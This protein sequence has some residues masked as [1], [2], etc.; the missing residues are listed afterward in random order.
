MNLNDILV[1]R[2]SVRKFSDKAVERETIEQVL[3]SALLAPSSRNSRSTKFLV[4]FDKAKI[5]RLSTMRDYGSSFLKGAPCAIV[6]MGDV[7]ATDLWEVNCS[8]SATVLQLALVDAGLVSCWVHVDGRPQLKELPTGATAQERV[9]EVVDI[10][11]EHRVL[12]I[13]A[14]GY[15]DFEPAALPEF[16]VESKI[17]FE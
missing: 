9:C 14:C 5:E 10:P 4:T 12:C 2:R 17:I 15:S 7:S 8:I 3:H 11:K 6:V 1:K 16:D 13:V